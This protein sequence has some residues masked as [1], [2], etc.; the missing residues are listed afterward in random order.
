MQSLLSKVNSSWLKRWAIP[1]WM[2]KSVVTI[3]EIWYIITYWIIRTSFIN[4]DV[5]LNTSWA[6]TDSST[7]QFSYL[8]VSNAYWDILF[9]GLVKDIQTPGMTKTNFLN[10]SNTSSSFS[11]EFTAPSDW[12]IYY[13]I[14]SDWYYA[15]L[16]VKIQWAYF[17]SSFRWA[18]SWSARSTSWTFFVKKW[19]TV[20]IEK[21][22]SNSWAASWD[23]R[24]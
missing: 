22:W 3:W 15:Y 14:Y 1:F 2:P 17:I 12:F 9:N 8:G 11:W 5:Y 21:S 19:T 6:I 13:Y 20:K 16:D 24:W 4:K 18:E 7:N 23:F 10:K